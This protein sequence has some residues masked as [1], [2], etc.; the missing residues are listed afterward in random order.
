MRLI[1]RLMQTEHEPQTNL[2]IALG[3]GVFAAVIAMFA[4]AMT[5]AS[6]SDS[7]DATVTAAIV[8]ERGCIAQYGPGER[9]A[10]AKPE[11][12]VPMVD[13]PPYILS[14]PIAES[15]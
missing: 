8:A 13:A 3:L 15:K 1:L 10:R 11:A 12:C 14:M 2:F 9:Y 7:T 4:A 6:L 5:G